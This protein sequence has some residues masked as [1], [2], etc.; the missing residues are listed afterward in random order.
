MIENYKFSN[1]IK[2]DFPLSSKHLFK[3]KAGNAKY[4][5]QLK[6][7]N[8]LENDLKEISRFTQENNIPFR[9]FGM[10]TNIYITDNGYNGLFIDITPQNSEIKFNKENETFT[11]SGNLLVSKLVNYT[12]K[13]GYDFSAF[14]GVPG[15][16]GSGIVGNA[17]WTP[18]KKSFSDFVQEITAFDFNT[19]E[20]IKI[21]PNENFFSERN[22]LIKEQN[23]KTTR[24]FVKEA[25]LKAEY[26]GEQNV[27]EKYI[28][29]ITK[30][31]NSLRNGF[32]DGCAGSIW[33]NAY[34]KNE[35]GKSFPMMLKENPIF[36]QNY[37]GARYGDDGSMFFTT[38][39]ET[40][41]K[42]VA[43][44]LVHTI[45]KL[46]EIYNVV[47]KKEMLIL[48]YDGEIDLNTF[49]ERNINIE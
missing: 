22:S 20:Y 9:I 28:A 25:I 39:T 11:V 37:N 38:G 5:Y 6:F 45:N 19:K 41:D 3:K 1:E 47:P 18:T 42:D 2:T 10:H 43:K 13:M 33:S 44:L 46:K 31:E 35:T 32:K 4:Y 36:K 15:M 7:D 34:L 14:T 12:M 23:Q 16:V 27:R 40:T 26:I 21:I 24:Y 17:G 30:R 29:Q 48:D 8:N 49:I